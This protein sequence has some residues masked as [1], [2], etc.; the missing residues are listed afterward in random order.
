MNAISHEAY[1]L[2]Y[3]P[4]RYGGLDTDPLAGIMLPGSRCP[5][6]EWME[7]PDRRPPLLDVVRDASEFAKNF[8]RTGKS[9]SAVEALAV[10][11]MNGG[12]PAQCSE[13]DQH[14]IELLKK[15]AELA[16]DVTPAGERAY[17]LVVREIARAQ[18]EITA[19]KQMEQGHA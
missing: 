13:A 5:R 18:A 7:L 4:R 11:A 8:L 15:Q 3:H 14:L 9:S 12:Q 16:E 10:P 6:L 19:E 1:R 17:T 2:S